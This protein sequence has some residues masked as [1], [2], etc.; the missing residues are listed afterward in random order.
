MIT[1]SEASNIVGNVKLGIPTQD[2]LD[3]ALEYADS[4]IRNTAR[5]GKS[6]CTL[7]FQDHGM[8]P[9]KPGYK[10]DLVIRDYICERL[11]SHGFTL[12]VDPN[13]PQF[14]DVSWGDAKQGEN[15]S[16]YSRR[17]KGLEA[18]ARC[19]EGGA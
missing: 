1:A 8:D 5:W 13:F 6:R 4:T 15:K 11:T 9:T 12:K 3:S 16:D 19:A 14:V 10:K 17:S 18:A 2:E 7:S